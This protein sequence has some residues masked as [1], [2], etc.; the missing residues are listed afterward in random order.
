MLDQNQLKRMIVRLRKINAPFVVVDAI[1]ERFAEQLKETVTSICTEIGL[2]VYIEQ[3]DA[4]L[5]I[6]NLFFSNN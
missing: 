5:K 6:R 2:M 1:E 3:E 4:Q